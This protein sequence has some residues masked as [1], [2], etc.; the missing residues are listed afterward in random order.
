MSNYSDY[1]KSSVQLFSRPELHAVEGSAIQRRTSQLFIQNGHTEENPQAVHK[2]TMFESL[3]KNLQ[4]LGQNTRQCASHILQSYRDWKAEGA[5]Q[6]LIP[7]LPHM[8]LSQIWTGSA[9]A[10]LP[11]LND[12]ILRAQKK[13]TKDETIYAASFQSPD[14][15][16]I[17]RFREY[18]VFPTYPTKGVELTNR[19]KAKLLDMATKSSS[20]RTIGEELLKSAEKGTPIYM[21]LSPEARELMQQINLELIQEHLTDI[22]TLSQHNAPAGLPC[23]MNYFENEVY[24]TLARGLSFID[25]SLLENA[26]IKIPVRVQGDQFELKEFNINRFNLSGSPEN[27]QVNHKT[28]HPIFFLTPTVN[29]KSAS[30][31]I[32]AR[33]TLLADDGRDGAKESIQADGRKDISLKWIANN[34]VLDQ[35]MSQLHQEYGAFNVCGHSLGGNIATLLTVKYFSMIKETVTISGAQVNESIRKRWDEILPDKRPFLKHI[36]VEGDAVPGG[37]VIIGEAV[38]AEQKK[39]VNNRSEPD[40]KKNFVERHLKPFNNDYVRYAE[41]DIQK[42]NSKTTRS[43]SSGGVHGLGRLIQEKS[44]KNIVL[45]TGQRETIYEELEAFINKQLRV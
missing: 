33:G 27:N 45:G 10:N 7:G 23:N 40:H 42:E 26:T 3:S 5:G 9:L 20:Y 44:L 18:S 6:K 39:T 16:V 30:P 25:K 35:K 21:N 19:H 31:M 28:G 36:M 29:D 14:P 34:E 17:T 11:G 1:T 22:H 32:V 38:I 24:D 12:S 4:A 13:G 2:A 8:V 15:Q 37:G 41:I 43:L